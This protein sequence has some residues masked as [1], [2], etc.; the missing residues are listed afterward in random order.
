MKEA[1]V[2]ADRQSRRSKGI[3]YVEFESETSVTPVRIEISI[4]YVQLDNNIAHKLLRISI[5]QYHML[6]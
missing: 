4:H 2:I 6:T 3:A 5:S 1:H